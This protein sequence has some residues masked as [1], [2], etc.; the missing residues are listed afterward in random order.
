LDAI[1]S[2]AFNTFHPYVHLHHSV[3]SA[4]W[5]LYPSAHSLLFY[6]LCFWQPISISF[7]SLLLSPGKFKELSCLLHLCFSCLKVVAFEYD[8]AVLG[9]RYFTTTPGSSNEISNSMACF[10]NLK[11]YSWH[12]VCTLANI[13]AISCAYPLCIL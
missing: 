7:V 11:E 12:F 8:H 13:T 6:C 5:D 9:P 1:L 10:L 3:C 2:E 4:S